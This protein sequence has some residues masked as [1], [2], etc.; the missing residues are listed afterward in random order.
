MSQIIEQNNHAGIIKCMFPSDTDTWMN[1]TRRIHLEEAL[2]YVPLPSIGNQRSVTMGYFDELVQFIMGLPWPIRLELIRIETEMD[3]LQ[4]PMGITLHFSV[5]RYYTRFREMAEK[6]KFHEKILFV[7]I[8]Q[9]NA[10]TENIVEKMSIDDDEILPLFKL[11]ANN[12]EAHFTTAHILQLGCIVEK[13]KN[14]CIKEC[15]DKCGD[16][17]Y[18]EKLATNHRSSVHKLIT[19]E[20]STRYDTLFPDVKELTLYDSKMIAKVFGNT[21]GAQDKYKHICVS[22]VHKKHDVDLMLI[23]ALETN[24]SYLSLNVSIHWFSY[25]CEMLRNRGGFLPIHTS[26]VIDSGT[27]AFIACHTPH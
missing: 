6:D 27:I 21:P 23:N 11:D 1:M 10:M 14:D 4:K 25:V 20:E 17:A 22:G 18:I 3:L 2:M 24:A 26:F 12:I 15:T 9:L 19:D 16:M 8:A 13:L 7:T 5:S